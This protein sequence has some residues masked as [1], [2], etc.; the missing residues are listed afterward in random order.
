MV[1]QTGENS[2]GSLLT[3]GQ[4]AKH[5]GLRTSALRYYE[6]QGLLVPAER[7]DA[8]YR[9]YKPEAEE[10]LRFIQ[11]AQRL[12]FA[13]EDIRILLE[14]LENNVIDEQA[15]AHIAEERFLE[16]ERQLTE[17]LVL[18]HEMR[19]FI[20][21]LNQGASGRSLFERLLDRVCTG[22]PGRLSADT[23]LA[24]LIERTGCMLA[25]TDLES[26]ISVLRG[27]HIHIWQVNDAYQ[28]LVTGHDEMV[29]SALVELADVEA[30]C[31]THPTPQ[32]E[33]NEEGFLFTVH[34][35][36]AFIFTQLFLALEQD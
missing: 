17:Q 34:G 28:I 2:M 7:S 11:R 15:I 6:E 20:S 30:A 23:L 26:I 32:L 27:Q 33:Q 13:L 10:T 31:N 12:G 1:N 22:P 24:W 4:L 19:L 35:E 29:H 18:R 25:S 5:A 16:M 3:I 36:N 21:D 8:G 9:L 14:G